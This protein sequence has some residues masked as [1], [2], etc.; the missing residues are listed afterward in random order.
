[1]MSKKINK[2]M[3]LFCVTALIIIFLRVMTNLFNIQMTQQGMSSAV[4]GTMD[5]S[6]KIDLQVK[7][8]KKTDIYRN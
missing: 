6:I 8:I 5:E 7:K 2:Y 1:M 3:P 4:A